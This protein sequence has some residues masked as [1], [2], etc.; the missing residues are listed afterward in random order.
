M[1][2]ASMWFP[3]TLSGKLMECGFLLCLNSS[4]NIQNTLQIFSQK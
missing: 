3:F 4:E 1:T 2:Q